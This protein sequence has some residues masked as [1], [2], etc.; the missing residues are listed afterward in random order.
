MRLRRFRTSAAVLA[1]AALVLTACG[2][3]DTG[4][5]S[6]ETGS[7]TEDMTSEPATGETTSAAMA[8]DVTTLTE[9]H[10]DGLLRHPLRALRVRGGRARS[11]ASTST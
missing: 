5:E 9:G 8:G 7:P 11:R 6:T 10:P 3:D 1:A 4:G 2:G